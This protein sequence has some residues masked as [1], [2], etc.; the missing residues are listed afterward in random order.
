MRIPPPHWH[1]GPTLTLPAPALTRLGARAGHW[2][3]LLAGRSCCW[4][5]CLPDLC[6]VR[7]GGTAHA[8]LRV[9]D[10]SL[11]CVHRW[12]KLEGSDPVTY[13]MIQKIQT[14]QKRLI[15]KT[16]EV[17]EKDMLI[18]VGRPD[19]AQ[20]LPRPCHGPAQTLPRPCPGPA[21]ALQQGMDAEWMVWDGEWLTRAFGAL[22]PPALPGR[23]TAQLMKCAHS[24]ITAAAPLLCATAGETLLMSAWGRACAPVGVA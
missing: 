4:S 23:R 3:S 10:P 5:P 21:T 12:R 2:A 20:A 1:A 7:T 24:R 17:V 9:P 8:R 18:Q 14:L 11:R 13:E 19:P 15:G 22:P 16:E 6:G